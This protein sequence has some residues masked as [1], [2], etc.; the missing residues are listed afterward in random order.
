MRRGVWDC[1]RAP[2]TAPSLRCW[3]LRPDADE[4][5]AEMQKPARSL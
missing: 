5:A 2:Y 3:A 4:T 1:F